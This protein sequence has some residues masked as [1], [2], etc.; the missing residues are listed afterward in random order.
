MVDPVV[1]VVDAVEL[2]RVRLDLLAPL[3]AAHGTESVREVILVRVVGDEG[4]GWGECS[5]LS[6]PG[7]STEYTDGAWRVLRDELAPRLV[8]GSLSAVDDN[9]MANPMARA[10][11]DTAC[12]D[13]RLRHAGRSLRD[14]LGGVREAVETTAVVGI[15]PT[16]EALVAAVGAHLDRGVAGVKLKITPQSGLDHLGI[17]RRTWPDLALAADANASFDLA[18]VP[19]DAIDRL[20]LVY[21]EQPLAVDRVGDLVRLAERLATPI[22]LDET[23]SSL[24][25][26]IRALEAGCGRVVNVKP[27]RLGGVCQAAKLV[28]ECARRGI[29]VFVGGML[30]TGIGRAAALAVAS[31]EGCTLATDLGPSERYF[32]TDI[33]EAITT[34]P[35]G[36]VRIPT[37]VG[38]GVSPI[39][40][41][42]VETTVEH[43]VVSRSV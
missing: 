20:G 18:S 17:V 1:P 40:E 2:I 39:P 42:L 4:E 29:D 31:L 22:A 23:S 27:A 15:L 37:G 8:A 6:R 35:T 14:E 26:T 24:D 9:P 41:R 43:A 3:Q 33:T 16:P 5:T 30:E 19:I 21:L 12:L 13:L 32:G 28:V 38:I 34:D 25:A 11:L 7:Y 36:L 10:A